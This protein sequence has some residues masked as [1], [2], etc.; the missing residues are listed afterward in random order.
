VPV[1]LIE[2]YRSPAVRVGIDTI[3][4]FINNLN[5]LIRWSHELFAGKQ[6]ITSDT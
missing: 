1:R 6:A 2:F 3:C 4:Y 5:I